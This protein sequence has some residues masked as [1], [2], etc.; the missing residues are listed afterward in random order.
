MFQDEI[1]CPIVTRLTEITFAS[2]VSSLFQKGTNEH[3]NQLQG[4]IPR[5]GQKSV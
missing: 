2:L 3:E 4:T 1:D 5:A